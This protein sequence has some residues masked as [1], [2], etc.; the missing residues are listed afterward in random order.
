MINDVQ[1]ATL[2]SLT[3]IS[4]NMITLTNCTITNG[5]PMP[6]YMLGTH[7][8]GREDLE[9]VCFISVSMTWAC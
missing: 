4:E 9:V 5:K 3:P 1:N 2:A 8:N 6:K 7:N